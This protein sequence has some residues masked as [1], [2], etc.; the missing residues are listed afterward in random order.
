MLVPHAYVST[1]CVC[2]YLMRSLVV[3][4]PFASSL[5]V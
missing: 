5:V 4:L 1:A 2:K 3:Y